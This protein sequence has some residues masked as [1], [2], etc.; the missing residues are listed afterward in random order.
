M[1]SARVIQERA[2]F[3]RIY[4]NKMAK[5]L[6]DSVAPILAELRKGNGWDKSYL[7]LLDEDPVDEVFSEIVQYPKDKYVVHEGWFQDTLPQAIKEIDRI[8]ILRLDGDYYES[9]KVC[10]EYLYPK[11]VR[12]GAVIVD[13]WCLKGCREACEEYFKAHQ[14]DP[15]IHFVDVCVRYFIKY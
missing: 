6:R 3:S 9:T 15:L 13:D 4:S 1:V 7:L 2:R 8:A 11:V 5:A 10:L 14:I 12:G